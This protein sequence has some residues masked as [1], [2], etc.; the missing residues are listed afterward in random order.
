MIVMQPEIMIFKTRDE[1]NE[2][3]DLVQDMNLD[4]GS[5]IWIFSYILSNKSFRDNLA[6]M[7]AMKE[8]F[9]LITEENVDDFLKCFEYLPM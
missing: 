9:I 6:M 7:E 3:Y 8:S 1:L 5:N 4:R 2:I